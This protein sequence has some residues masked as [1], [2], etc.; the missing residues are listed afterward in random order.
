MSSSQPIAINTATSASSLTSKATSRNFDKQHQQIQPDHQQNKQNYGPIQ[1]GNESYSSVDSSDSN[2]NQSKSLFELCIL[3]GMHKNRDGNFGGGSSSSS[4]K[5]TR[6]V[7]SHRSHKSSGQADQNTTQSNPNLKQFDSLPLQGKQMT[8]NRHVRE[9]DR[10]DEKLLMECI[11]TGIMKKIGESNKQQQVSPSLLTREA[12]VLHNNQPKNGQATSAAAQLE[13]LIHPQSA[14]STDNCNSSITTVSSINT[15][16]TITAAATDV[17]KKDNSNSNIHTT[18]SEI[19]SPP[20]Q[21]RNIN[22]ISQEEDTNDQ[23][24]PFSSLPRAQENQVSPP[25]DANLPNPEN[26]QEITKDIGYKLEHDDLNTNQSDESNQSFIMETTVSLETKLSEPVTPREKGS[27]KHKDPDLMLK[28]VERL[29]LEFVSSAEQLRTNSSGT[30]QCEKQTFVNALITSDCCG[31]CTTTHSIS[32][33]TWD[34]DTCPNDVSFP[35]VSISAPKIISITYD[36]DDEDQATTADYKELNDFAENTPI[37]DELPAPDLS[38]DFDNIGVHPQNGYNYDSQPSSLECC[39]E[40]EKT[41][42]NATNSTKEELRPQEVQENSFGLNFKLGG[43]VQTAAATPS[44]FFNANSMTNSTFIA[45]EARKLANNLQAPDIDGEEELTFSINSLDLDNIRPP[46]GMDSLNIS[47]YYQDSTQPN[48]LQNSPQMHFKSPKFPRKTLP[49]GLVARRALGH[50]PPHLTGSVE[51]INS[52]C[53]LLLDNIKPPSL[54]DELLD[55]MI[56]VSSIQSEIAD[57]C[58]SMATTVTVSN[59]ETAT[60]GGGEDGDTVTLQSYCED[61]LLKDEDCTFNDGTITPLP[62]DYDF[63]SAESTPKKSYTASPL[64]IRNLTPKE[65]RQLVKDRYRTYTIDGDMSEELRRKIEESQQDETLQIEI[66]NYETNDKQVANDDDET[67]PDTDSQSTPR[68]RRR[69]SQERYRTQT[70]TYSDLQMNVTETNSADSNTQIRTSNDTSVCSIN[71]MTQNFKF[72]NSTTRTEEFIA[73]QEQDLTS[74]DYDQNSETE[75]C[76]NFGTNQQALTDCEE[77]RELEEAAEAE[78]ER[79]QEIVRPRIVKPGENDNEINT[80]TAPEEEHESSAKA[81]RGGKKPQYVS[82]YSIKYQ[83]TN[84]SPKQTKIQTPATKTNFLRKPNGSATTATTP[85][86]TKLAQKKTIKET[87]K[88]STMAA[89]PVQMPPPLE[90]QGTFVKDEPSLDASNVPVVETSPKKSKLSKLPTKRQ[91][92]ATNMTSPHKTASTRK[93]NTS[94]NS[95][96]SSLQTTTK[97]TVGGSISKPQRANSNVNIRVTTNAARIAVL[98]TRVSTTT[99]PSRSNSTLNSANAA[100]TAAQNA[101]AKINQAQSRI[102]GIWRKV[103]EAKN[104]QQTKVIKGSQQLSGKTIHATATPSPQPGKL[105]RSTTFDNSPSLTITKPKPGVDGG[106]KPTSKIAMAQRQ[107]LGNRK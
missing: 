103:D 93:L 15:N 28:S 8:P 27:D 19:L 50:M 10:R 57:D 90:R 105:V 30:S 29:T 18:Q 42:V 54:M 95:S 72:T 23:R 70:I 26:A 64:G 37:I 7:H 87:N 59:Y 82:P 68:S 106:T 79:K 49:A 91:L 17:E 35:S 38:L 107:I 53:N 92:S 99:P 44:L 89:E 45:Q 21:P 41:L 104:K 9:R 86:N 3:T 61:Q 34:E 48:S 36:E 58:A 60:A 16:T 32:N 33:D 96:T 80:Q 73:K 63:S 100:V 13:E 85:T 56:S 101:A 1:A 55:S 75:S 43:I 4:R 98:S 94:S 76:H 71:T 88:A 20:H 52:S 97:R 5:H 69:S 74:L 83:K 84:E 12:L 46:S 14:K 11:N 6:S 66:T 2:D 62:S 65:K 39:T 78:M 22:N 51:S 40:T 102:A 81:I 25:P 77:E 31:D 67:K 47:G 24:N